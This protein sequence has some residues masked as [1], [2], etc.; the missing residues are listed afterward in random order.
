MNTELPIYDAALLLR[1][2][3]YADELSRC[4]LIEEW[5]RPDE[6]DTTERPTNDDH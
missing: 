5:L 3:A 6:Q 1:E 2:F 4:Q